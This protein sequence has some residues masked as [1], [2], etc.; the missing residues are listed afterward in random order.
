[1]GN[2]QVVPSDLGYGEKNLQTY[3]VGIVICLFLTFLPFG[4]VMLE[5]F[6]QPTTVGLIVA[7]ALAQFIVQLICFLR[8]NF[9][10]RQAKMNVKA[11]AYTLFMIFV[12]LAGSMWVMVT[13]NYRMMH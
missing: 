11:F 6:S 3:V 5:F 8:L 1:M 13:L 12:L 4:A 10:T 2:H 7:C 9:H